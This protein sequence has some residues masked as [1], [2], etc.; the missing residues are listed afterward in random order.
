MKC[1]RDGEFSISFSFGVYWNG[2]DGRT[3]GWMDGQTNRWID[4]WTDRLNLLK[5]PFAT[6]KLFPEVTF[7]NK[8]VYT[9]AS[10]MYGW[11]EAVM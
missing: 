1:Q 10:V 3:D 4:R 6:K 5:L 9:T 2:P 7:F 8:A 11:A